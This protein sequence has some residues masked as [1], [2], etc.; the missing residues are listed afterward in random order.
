MAVDGGFR[1]VAMHQRLEVAQII[2]ELLARHGAVLPPFP[3]FRLVRHHGRGAETA[4]TGRP[5]PM[6]VG[7]I[8]TDAGATPAFHGVRHPL[9]L[10]PR[11]ARPIPPSL[12]DQPPPPPRHRLPPPVTRLAITTL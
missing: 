2:A 1:A 12:A 6:L 4:P 9:G 7:G 3:A 10:P 11:L 5:A 8:G